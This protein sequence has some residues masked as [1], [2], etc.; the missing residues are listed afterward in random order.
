MNETSEKRRL[1][2]NTAA[3]I[4]DIILSIIALVAIPT[5]VVEGFSEGTTSSADGFLVLMLCG[6]VLHIVGLIK[7]KKV[8]ISIVGNILGII[9][10]GIYTFLGAIVS[11]PSMVLLILACIFNF[12]QKNID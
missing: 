1:K 5:I 4:V 8:G 11:F 12:I 2:I 9:G 3:A 7:S 10:T 6:L